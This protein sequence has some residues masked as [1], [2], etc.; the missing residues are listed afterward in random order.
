MFPPPNIF[1]RGIRSIHLLA[2][3][4]VRVGTKRHR[5]GTIVFHPRRIRVHNHRHPAWH[6]CG[7]GRQHTNPHADTYIEAQSTPPVM[8]LNK[9]CLYTHRHP[10]QTNTHFS[11]LLCPKGN[12]GLCRRLSRFRSSRFAHKALGGAP[13]AGG[14]GSGVWTLIGHEKRR[15]LI[16]CVY[17]SV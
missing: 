10:T 7:L 16:P 12:C 3:R 5:V 4:P 9:H 6:T 2:L 8:I 17:L 13:V 15:D 11:P 1:S 14:A